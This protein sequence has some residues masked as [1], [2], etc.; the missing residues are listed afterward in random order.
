MPWRGPCYRLMGWWAGIPPPG[1]TGGKGKKCKGRDG[2]LS[3]RREPCLPHPSLM[4]ASKPHL[5]FY[6]HTHVRSNLDQILSRSP[7]Q[8]SGAVP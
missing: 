6:I 4:V 1:E 8:G 3:G 5:E 2:H 7:L